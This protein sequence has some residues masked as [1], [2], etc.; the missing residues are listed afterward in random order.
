MPGNEPQ[1]REIS[2]KS[3]EGK[4]SSCQ[5]LQQEMS[6]ECSCCAANMNL[7][8][9]ST[10]RAHTPSFTVTL[11]HPPLESSNYQEMKYLLLWIKGHQSPV[12]VQAL[13]GAVQSCQLS[14]VV[15]NTMQKHLGVS[16]PPDVLLRVFVFR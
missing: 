8:I 5:A 9:R 4:A 15:W 14:A 3:V 6:P 12:K 1:E 2:T 10:S 16:F 11:G 7:C 13:K